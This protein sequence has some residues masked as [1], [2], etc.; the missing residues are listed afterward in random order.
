[1]VVEYSSK[2]IAVGALNLFSGL[3][4]AVREFTDR[5]SWFSIIPAFCFVFGL[6]LVLAFKVYA[7][8]NIYTSIHVRIFHRLTPK[9]KIYIEEVYYAYLNKYIFIYINLFH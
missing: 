6:T 5:Q 1:M 7:V 8:Y 3:G 9:S 2:S 4:D